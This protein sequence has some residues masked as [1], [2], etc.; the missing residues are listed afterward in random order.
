[1]SGRRGKREGGREERRNKKE[2][3]GRGEMNERKKEKKEKRRRGEEERGGRAAVGFQ[4]RFATCRSVCDLLCQQ[5]V[6]SSFFNKH[7]VFART[8][9]LLPWAF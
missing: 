3:K 8:T 1:M 9:S 2:I 6:T 5:R 4:M 7:L